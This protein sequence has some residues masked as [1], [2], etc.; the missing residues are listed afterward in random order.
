MSRSESVR[1]YVLGERATEVEQTEEE[2]VK[3]VNTVPAA[4]R[5]LGVG[6]QILAD[7]GVTKLTVLSNSDRRL[8]GLDAY[9]LELCGVEEIPEPAYRRK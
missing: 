6:C 4:F 7:C 1:R 3:A 2:R 9:G 5:D 8:V